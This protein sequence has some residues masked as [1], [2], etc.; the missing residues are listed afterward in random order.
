[1][2]LMDAIAAMAGA[3]PKEQANDPLLGIYPDMEKRLHLTPRFLLD[4][5]AVQAAVDLSLGRPKVLVEAMQHL[6]V[7]FPRLW[8][9]WEESDRSRLIEVFQRM[10]IVTPPGRPLP[11]RLGFL[12]E[13]DESGRAGTVTWVWTSSGIGIGGIEIPNVSPITAYWDLDQRIDY[14]IAE[15][16][17]RLTMVKLWEDN[18]VQLAALLDLWRTADHLPSEWGTQWLYAVCRNQDELAERLAYCYA[19]VYGEY[20]MAWA[21]MMLLTSSRRTVDYQPVDRVKINKNRARKRQ[22]PLLDHTQVIMHL[23]NSTLSSVRRAPLGHAR[24][25]PRVH[26]VSR[27]LARRGDKHWIVQP[28]LRGVGE[29]VQRHVHVR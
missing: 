26:L 28:Y 21:V 17:S 3:T 11:K 15:R 20:I 18:P 13:A 5:T 27:Y 24:K 10:T 19:D 1:M 29:G 8:V 7:P 14:Q 22:V 23:G 12:L 25:S 4:R 2:Y 6:H 9:E 16:R